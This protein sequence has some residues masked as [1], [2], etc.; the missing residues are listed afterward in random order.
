MKTNPYIIGD[1]V[2]LPRKSNGFAEG[3][4]WR[5]DKVDDIHV[6]IKPVFTVT[7]R[8]V[9]RSKKMKHPQVERFSLFMFADALHELQELAHELY[10]VRSGLPSDEPMETQ[11]EKA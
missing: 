3:V 1:I 8:S 11:A 6:W 10:R 4:L 7:G 2:V 5:V 9:L